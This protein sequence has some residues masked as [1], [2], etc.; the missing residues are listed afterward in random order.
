MGIVLRDSLHQQQYVEKLE[1][2]LRFLINE[3]S[4]TL[5]DLDAVWRAQA[6][7][8]EAIVKNVHD[9]LAKLAWDF[10]PEHID[11]LFD[12]FEA[13]MTTA[14]VRQR[15][16]L[17]ELIRQLAEEDKNGLVA[18]KVLKLFWQLAHSPDVLQDVM[19]Q[20][21]AAHVKILDYS[22]SQERDAQKS[23]WLVKCVEELK[24]NENWVL[25]A[26][27]LIR[28]I[29]CLYELPLNHARNKTLNRQLV[30]ERLQTEHT[31]VILVTN[32]LTAYLERVRSY[33]K[34]HPDAKPETVMLDGKYP[35]QQQIQERLD[36][37]RFL[38]KDGQLW[39][40]ADQAEQIWQ[41]LTVNPAFTSDR[42]ECFRW[43]SK[44]MG[45]EPDLD[46]GINR[47]FLERNLLELDPVLLSESGIKCFER[48]FKAVNT[49]ERKLRKIRRSYMLESVDLIGKDYL[50]QIITNSSEEIS[51]KAI[52]L[53]KEVST[54]FSLRLQANITELHESFIGE[55]CERL[56]SYY[57]NIMILTNTMDAMSQENPE[58]TDLKLRHIEAEKMCRVIRVLVEYIKECDRTFLGERFKL[59]LAR[60]H[61]GKHISLYFRF[62]N[63]GRPL[64]DMEFN[65][66]SNEMVCSLKRNLLKKL[67]GTLNNIKVDFYYSNGELIEIDD[68]L[69]PIGQY[70]FRDKTMLTVKLTPFN[71]G[72]KSSPDSS[73]DSSTGSP[74]RPCPNI[75]RPESEWTLPGVIISQ[76]PQHLEFFLKL[77]QLGSDIQNSVLRDS[78]RN[79]LQLL[80]A[81]SLTVRKLNAMCNPLS[82]VED[83][84]E[85]PT[86]ESMF[87]HAL[88]AQVLYNLEVLHAL[89][90]PA[91]DPMSIANLQFDSAWV[92]SGVAHFILDLLTKN[93][94]LPNADMH[95]KRTAFQNVLRLAKIFLYIVGCVLSRVGDDPPTSA[96]FDSG[97][98][99]IEILKTALSSTFCNSEYILRSISIKLAENLATEMLS[100]DPEGETCRKLFASALEWSCP[101][102]QTIKVI[103]QIAWASSCGALQQLGS[104]N[105][106]SHIVARPEVPDHNVCREALEVLTISLALNPAA[107][108]SLSRD[109]VWP[110]F[111][112]SILLVNPMRQIRQSAADQLYLSCTYC[113]SGY[114]P[115]VF[116]IKLLVDLLP[117]VVPQHSGTCGEYFQLLCRSLNYGCMYNWPLA[118]NDILLEQ[119]IS[120]LRSVR[121]V[122]KE[123]GE[124]QV[125]EDLLEGH[126]CLTKELMF[127]L[128]PELKLQ[129]TELITVTFNLT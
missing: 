23:I 86:P 90:T 109:P 78:C 10:N 15:E 13:S 115:F 62:T 105:D 38:L 120:W 88:P 42:E 124:T 116:V 99:Q 3:K 67:K 30:V 55:C 51:I 122:V 53:L 29:C 112:T 12:C 17:L 24:T 27:R 36:F 9:L 31:L 108:E 87:L 14:N 128:A 18:N 110:K 111:I 75:Q 39:L 64:D 92:H 95:T 20:A 81:D 65:T 22:C 101:N 77:C 6:G 49:K 60:A 52:K 100:A 73:S 50:W 82:N 79:L 26:L 74:P 11:H 113:A 57:D 76:K 44:L 69:D 102:V 96:E 63:P 83:K 33:L 46:P 85:T 70:A 43:F 119:E 98:T 94:F 7:K 117:E 21:L 127:F 114:Q 61:R 16:R 107:N 25:P 72:L 4:L 2:I 84:I 71:P 97:R 5:E 56:R 48:F 68:N 125:H 91:L 93:N 47:E 19:D 104:C 58:S 59:P 121:D 32:S 66:H 89:L 35:H 41:C 37:L 28:E 40:C 45:D 129:L 126:L 123:T 103:V 8:H 118:I 1:K 34:E 106:F 54:A 80:P